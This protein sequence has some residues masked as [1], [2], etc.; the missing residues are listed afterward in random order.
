M[1]YEV[2]T[3]ESFVKFTANQAGDIRFGMG[4][5]KGVGSGAVQNIIDVRN[6]KG[7]FKTIYDLVENVNLQAVNKKNLEALAMAGAFDTLKGVKRSS[8]FAGEDE[9]DNTTFIEKLIRSYNFV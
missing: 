7:H 9:N 5:V 1:L 3:N 8:F 4:A 6:E 2:I